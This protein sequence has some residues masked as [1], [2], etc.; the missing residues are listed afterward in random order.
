MDNPLTH[1]TDAMLNEIC[2]GQCKWMAECL[3]DGT[4]E[5]WTPHLTVV[6]LD[7]E[8]KQSLTMMALHVPFNEAREKAT[9]MMNCGIAAAG[10]GLKERKIPVAAV[11]TSEVWRAPQKSNCEPRHNP[12]REEA[13]LCLA[14]TGDNRRASRFALITRIR[15]CIRADNFQSQE[16][17]PKSLLNVFWMSVA[18]TF[19]AGSPRPTTV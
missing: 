4:T 5:S 18:K 2:D 14:V 17:A 3:A 8:R 6:F 7:L 13:L 10:Q 12:D 16:P 9:A 19:L 11:L 1:F 15:G